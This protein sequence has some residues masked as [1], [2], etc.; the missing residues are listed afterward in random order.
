MEAVIHPLLQLTSLHLP[1][2]QAPNMVISKGCHRYGI[3]TTPSFYKMY[4]CFYTIVIISEI[5]LAQIVN[6]LLTW[7]PPLTLLNPSPLTPLTNIYFEY[8][9]KGYYHAK[10]HAS[11]SKIDQVMAILVHDPPLTPL[12]APP[13][14]PLTSLYLSVEEQ[15]ISNWL[16]SPNSLAKAQSADFGQLHY[17]VL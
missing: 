7:L 5:N 4:S 9:V 2:C 6:F 11:S 1:I 17:I 3:I 10:F 15:N 16:Y 13:W 8:F 14:T 12:N